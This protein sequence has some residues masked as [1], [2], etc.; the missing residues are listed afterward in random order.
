MNRTDKPQMITTVSVA[1]GN[2]DT[3]FEDV[4][5]LVSNIEKEYSWNY[6]LSIYLNLTFEK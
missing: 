6:T 1:I 2:G 4:K 3:T 5:T